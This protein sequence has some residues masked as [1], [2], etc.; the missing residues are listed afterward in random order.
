MSID[1]IVSSFGVKS[2]TRISQA[3]N[4]RNVKTRRVKLSRDRSDAK[5]PR[6]CR[7][8]SDR[9]IFLSLDR[10]AA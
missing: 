9:L 10:A 8:H 3:I 2:S 5:D 4:Y 1:V 7:A 6:K